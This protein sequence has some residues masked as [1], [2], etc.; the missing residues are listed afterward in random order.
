MQ[1][2]QF[3]WTTCINCLH[4]FFFQMFL[5]ESAG[6]LIVFSGTT[7]EVQYTIA[8]YNRMLKSKSFIN[9]LCIFIFQK[10]EADMRNVITPLIT[11]FNAVFDKVSA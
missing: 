8:I 3:H 5:Y 1:D 10:Q 9:F 7:A 4:N 11:R 2:R 6:L